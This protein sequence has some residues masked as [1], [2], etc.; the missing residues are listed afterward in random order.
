MKRW[1][2]YAGITSLFLVG[3]GALAST[4]PWW[5]EEYAR[6]K[7]VGVLETKFESVEFEEFEL[8]RDR[9]IVK[10]LF[11]S[12]PHTLLSLPSVTVTFTPKFWQRK[13]V[14]HNIELEG[15]L[16]QGELEQLK[17]LKGSED[18]DQS[19]NSSSKIDLS[20]T[21][22]SVKDF[23][24][25]IRARG[26]R[27][28]GTATSNSSSI[29]GPF[30][31][32]LIRSSVAQ[33]EDV[34]VSAELLK[35]TLE[36]EELYPL[37]LH[38]SGVSSSFEEGRIK[39]VEG[40]VTVKDARAQQLK[41]DL[42]GKTESGQ[43]WMFNGEVNRPE[44]SARG[45]LVAQQ[46]KASQLPLELPLELEDGLITVDLELL[47]NKDFVAAQGT[48]NVQGLRVFHEWLARDPVVISGDLDLDAK[49]NLETRELELSSFEFRQPSGLRVQMKGRLLYAKEF[50]DR[51]L[52]FELEFPT[53]RCQDLLE[54]V[55][56]FLPALDG[57]ELDGV[58]YAFLEVFVK[59]DDPDATVLEGGL[60]LD[61]CRLKR[62]PET[63]KALDGSF[64]HL[65]R[66]KNGKVV[67]RPLMRGH[68]FYASWDEI[69]SSV[70]GAVLSTEDGGFFGHDGFRAQSFYNSLRRNVELG[71]FRRGASTLSMQMVKNVLLTHE[72]TISRK[73]QELFLTWVIEKRLSKTR[74]L[75]IY[76]NV[77]EFGPGIYGVEHAADHYF[78]KSVNQLTS[79]EAAFL[80]TLLPRPVERHAMWCRG[81]LT[82]K[83]ENRIHRVHRR[84]LSKSR[85]TQ[86]EFDEGEAQGITFSRAGWVS[87]EDCLADGKRVNSG[88][89]TQGALSGLL[90]SRTL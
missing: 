54:S 3:F 1:L 64:M 58:S 70:P 31:L 85:I 27:A 74:I 56:G 23:D 43:G 89:H 86:A 88:D 30:E 28:R 60:D 22:I 4:W 49:A 5:L 12:N 9:V 16:V 71:E 18:G 32:E 38:V 48:A 41:F 51:E 36:P 62:I 14:I 42:R 75:E 82:P 57:F 13:A 39:D 25:D 61:A 34:L 83:H 66:M 37:E 24:F 46:L 33:D 84:M 76:L 67:Q 72:K 69:P 52:E 44:A 73:M 47:K 45:H 29:K 77:V 26:Y 6:A 17:K 19:S 79:L 65:V 53:F 35:T 59:M 78:G 15:G 55:P 50:R 40:D 87:E 7:M 21:S 63:V 20:S 10:D 81:Q 68:P 11:V 8:E 2:K 90:G 80:A